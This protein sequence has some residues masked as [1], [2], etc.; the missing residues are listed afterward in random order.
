[1]IKKFGLWALSAA[2]VLSLVWGVNQYQ[3]AEGLELTAENQYQS[4]FADLVTHLDGLETSMAKSRAAGTP[5]Q[6][7]LHLSQSWQQSETAVKDLSQLPT[8]HYGLNYV[9]QFLNQIAEYTHLTTQQIAKG[10]ALSSDQDQTLKN[11][12]ERLIA[13]NRTVQELNVRL[14]TESIPWQSKNSQN[15]N[16]ADETTSPAAA[17]GEEGTTANPDSVSSGLE[18][19]DASLQKYPP[20]SYEGQTDTHLVAEPL[21]LPEKTVTEAEAKAAAADFLKTLGYPDAAPEFVGP[22]NGTFNVYVFKSGSTTV[23]VAKKGAVIT[24]FRDDREIGEQQYSPEQTAAR[25]RRTLKA[26]GWENFVQTSVS[27]AGSTIQLDAVAEEQNVRIY[28]DKIRL[29]VAKDNG[30]ITSYDATSYWLF[31]QQRTLLPKISLAQA[32]T[33]LRIDVSI[34]ES[35]LAVI[36][37]PG[38]PEAL[39]YEFRIQRDNEEYLIYINAV[40]GNEEKIQRIIRTPRGEYLE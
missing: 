21:G 38:W 2:L 31:H 40:N 30:K 7:V 28:P 18:Q 6:Q 35:R 20:Y 9:D 12:H 26:L 39:C 5:T 23:D 1:M 10:Q 27:D 13:V 25:T 16:G 14:R 11:M 17:I 34:E 32:K 19:L 33:R 22:S 24:Y 37:L 4:S 8:D 3:R 36:S 15:A 29:I